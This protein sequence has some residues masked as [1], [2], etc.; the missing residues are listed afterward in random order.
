MTPRRS[1]AARFVETCDAFHLPIV[2]FVDEPGFMIARPSGRHH[3]FRHG[4]AVRRPRPACRGGRVLR[5]SFG[6]AQGIHSA[7]A[8]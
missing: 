4:G 3:P 2:S 1:K 7:R 8:R 6:V 5:K